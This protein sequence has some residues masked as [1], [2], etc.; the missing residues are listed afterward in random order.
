[1]TLSAKSSETCAVCGR[2][3]PLRDLVPG[4]A[5]RDPV[6]RRIREAHADWEI[7]LE[8]LEEIGRRK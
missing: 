1:M 7:Q 6:A 3:F 5:V 4:A 2:P 8:L